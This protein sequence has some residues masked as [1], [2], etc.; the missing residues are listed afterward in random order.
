[1]PLYH[2]RPDGTASICEATK[3]NCPFGGEH[4]P[5]ETL[6][7]M[8]YERENSRSMFKVMSARARGRI[9]AL[10]LVTAISLSAC[11]APPD[12]HASEDWQ[13]YKSDKSYAQQVEDEVGKYVDVDKAKDKVH[14]L[15]EKG[16]EAAVKLNDY[17]KQKYQEWKDKHSDGSGS[18]FAAGDDVRFQGKSLS[19]TSQ[20]VNQALGRL[21]SLEVRPEREASGYQR[22]SMYGT[23]KSATIGKV[24]HRDLDTGAV[25]SGGKDTSRA[26]E[27]SF[28]D[29]Y[30]GRV[31]NVVQGS[32]TDVSMDHVVPLKEA[33]RSENP[34]RPLSREQRVA[35]ANDMDNLQLVGY[36]I[37]SSKSDK[38]PKQFLPTYKPGVCRYVLSYI[39]IKDRYGLSVDSGEKVALEGGLASCEAD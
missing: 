33:Y 5:S 15:A 37:N 26:V 4:Y 20:E 29:P 16:K 28:I 34:D 35:L 6:A 39:T 18:S 19:V 25:F 14:E 11:S 36:A 31:E 24:E 1:M 23:N 9:A 2:N 12:P 27:G 3:G 17:S 30:T 7:R 22:K 32:S 38:D 8:A 21:N 10:T 13:S